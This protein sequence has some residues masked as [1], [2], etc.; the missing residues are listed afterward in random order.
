MMEL[1]SKDDLPLIDHDVIRIIMSHQSILRDIRNK[2]KDIDLN[3]FTT[4]QM[5]IFVKFCQDIK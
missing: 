2:A 3:E 5:K 4:L 1:V